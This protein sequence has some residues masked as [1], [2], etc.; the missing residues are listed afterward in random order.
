[1]GAL[2]DQLLAW[3]AL[4]PVWAGLIVF[5][6]AM[7]ESLAIVGVI[8]PGV[9][10]MFG[11]GALI[12]AGALAFWPT[13]AW[14]VAGAVLG[15]GVSFFLG[16]HYQNQLR[17]FW[18]FSRHPEM[19]DQGV[20]FFQRYGGKSV[21]FG[22]FVG[23]VRAV[24]P[25][26]AGMLGMSPIRFLAA[27]VGSALAWA[28]AYLF[29]G[30][31]FGASLELASE[32]AF[33]LVALLMLL[34]ALLWFV[35]WLVKRVFRLIHP[36]AGALVGRLLLWSQLHPKLGEIGN[37]LADPEHGEGRGLALFASLLLT[38]T[39][40]FALVLT[41]VLGT[42]E[43]Q[44]LDQMLWQALQ[45]LRT[46][47]A[48]HLLVSFSRLADLGPM[49]GLGAAVAILLAWRRDW[50]SAGHWLAALAFGLLAAPLVKYLVQ[51]PRPDSGAA[52]LGPYAFPSAHV[53]R[54]T[55]IYGFLAVLIARALS[56]RWRWLPYALAGLATA[57]VAVARL[58]LGV[59]WLS[60]VLGSLSLGLIWISALGIAY[61]RHSRLKTGWPG[62]SLASV[63]ALCLG[64][65]L[66]TWLY[67]QQQ[68]AQYTP[69]RPQAEMALADWWRDGW[70][71]LPRLR[72]DTRG[73]GEHPFNVQ[74]AG[75]LGTLQ[76]VLE[77]AGWRPVQPLGWHNLLHLLSPSLTL[78]QL[79]VLPQVHDGRHESLAL[80]KPLANG[81]RLVLRLW[82]ADVRLSPTREPLW[83]GNVSAQAQRRMLHLFNFPQT[84][85]QSDFA[86]AQLSDDSRA[87]RQRLPDPVAHPH[88]FLIDG[89]S[90]GSVR[91]Y[92]VPSTPFGAA[93][94]SD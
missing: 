81:G 89:S 31:V 51:I 20:R 90:E 91:P 70:Q 56:P 29:P 37:A 85:A 73:R 83:L 94:S 44:S 15:D 66:Q 12:S 8:V 34:I 47:W 23:P 61:H 2:F 62:L 52:G 30:M 58:Y 45:S 77:P 41:A 53:L 26:V 86:S 35:A 43:G 40:L 13:L 36:R 19:L 69:Q 24:V 14:A 18:P 71:Q 68:V 46:P 72:V 39:V 21:V 93:G 50:S 67:H 59:H 22:R 1:V 7:A 63:A 78:Q 48:D 64:L 32:V 57:C 11:I 4:H 60:D 74:Y 42:G 84:L 82:P 25:L 33:R 49:L 38:A 28:P 6:V 3:V 5:L 76:R 55:V 88:F 80:E 10:M 75:D 65:G 54:A 27:N 79:P 17:G 87:L 16:R 9:A 92:S